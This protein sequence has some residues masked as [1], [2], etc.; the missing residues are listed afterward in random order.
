MTF[1]KIKRHGWKIQNNWKFEILLS[2]MTF[3]SFILT[4]CTSGKFQNFQS[5]FLYKKI[6]LQNHD[7]FIKTMTF[8]PNKNVMVGSY[9]VTESLMFLI[10]PW[11]FYKKN[12]MVE[13][14]IITENMIFFAQPW[15]FC[16]LPWH[17]VPP[18]NFK[19]FNQIF[20]QK[21]TTSWLKKKDRKIITFFFNYVRKVKSNFCT[22]NY[23]SEV[24][25]W[26]LLFINAMIQ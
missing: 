12:V 20:E 26:R 9:K 4:P 1:L 8:S 2:T 5:K 22:E 7:V 23:T 3:L 19:I 11:R 16:H 17:L 13:K 10:E 14:Y 18:K 15:R 21:N 25:P 24:R 6:L